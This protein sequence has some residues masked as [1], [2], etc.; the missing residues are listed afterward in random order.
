M[1]MIYLPNIP[2]RVQAL[3]T[4]LLGI[5]HYRS[6]DDISFFILE[7]WGRLCQNL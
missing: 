2:R 1:I 7:R 4:S 5:N 6:Y 3:N